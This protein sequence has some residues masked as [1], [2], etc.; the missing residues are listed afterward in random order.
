VVVLFGVVLAV[1]GAVGIAQLP[2]R[3]TLRA[4][5]GNLMLL[6]ALLAMVKF[7]RHR[8]RNVE[9]RRYEL[10]AELLSTLARDSDPRSELALRLDLSNSTSEDK[11]TDSKAWKTDRGSYRLV[12]YTDPWLELSGRLF[13]GTRYRVGWTDRVRLR[14]S[15]TGRKNKTKSKQK[16]KMTVELQLKVKPSKVAGLDCLGNA[17]KQE[18]QI[19]G[20]PLKS[21]KMAPDGIAVKASVPEA[22]VINQPGSESRKQAHTARM[23]LMGMYQAIGCA[24]QRRRRIAAG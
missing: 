15:V 20:A 6:A 24:K 13:D 16:R 23:L 17:L 5:V 10:C 14:R 11:H 22:H 3:D 8:Q 9:D 1:G 18:L 19:A 4:D 2:L 12:E 21:L 7:R